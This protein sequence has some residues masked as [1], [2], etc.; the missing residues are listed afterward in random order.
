MLI[1][2]VP[3][4]E[5]AKEGAGRPQYRLRAKTRLRPFVVVRS[6]SRSRHV[7]PSGHPP[8]E[9]SASIKSAPPQSP[10]AGGGD[11]LFSPVAVS[12]DGARA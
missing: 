2:G 1:V 7:L 5:N 8:V 10:F 9:M 6:G 11:E 3:A 4:V 12:L